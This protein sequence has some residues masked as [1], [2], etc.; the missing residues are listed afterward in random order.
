MNSQ[1]GTH[2]PARKMSKTTSAIIAKLCRSG[3]GA[4]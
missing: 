1:A 2:S 3:I 4:R